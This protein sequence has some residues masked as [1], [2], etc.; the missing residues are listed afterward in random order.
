MLYAMGFPVPLA[1][2]YRSCQGR[3]GRRDPAP[4]QAVL[5]SSL[6]EAPLAFSRNKKTKKNPT[7]HF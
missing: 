3:A 5:L 7:G 4:R 1:N 2:A 6:P